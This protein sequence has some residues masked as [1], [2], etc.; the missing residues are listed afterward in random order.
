MPPISLYT[1]CKRIVE[2]T[3]FIDDEMEFLKRAEKGLT[4]KYKF[5]IKNHIIQFYGVCDKCNDKK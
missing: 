5:A 4:K 2:Y 1:F 3:D